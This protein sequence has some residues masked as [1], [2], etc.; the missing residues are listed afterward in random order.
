MSAA[1]TLPHEL[2]ALV[3]TRSFA[4]WRAP[5]GESEALGAEEAVRRAQASPPILCHAP[6]TSRRLGVDHVEGYD[7][8]ELFALA[9]PAQF[10]LPTIRGL[11]RTLSI[12]AAHGGV[13]PIWL[14]GSSVTY[15]VLIGNIDRFESET[16]CNA[17]TSA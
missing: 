11:A 8:L 4:S 2:P 16:L 17:F 1:S 14:Q 3:A 10:T 9:R 15:H 12:N 13:R 6:A 5:S 7:V